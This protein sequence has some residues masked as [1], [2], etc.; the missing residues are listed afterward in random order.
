M[1]LPSYFD[2]AVQFVIQW[3]LGPS[4]SLIE[5]SVVW[6]LDGLLIVGRQFIGLPD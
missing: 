6:S 4:S 2:Y 1:P 5:F 3:L